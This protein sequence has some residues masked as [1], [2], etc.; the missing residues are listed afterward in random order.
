MSVARVYRAGSPFNGSELSEVD[1]EQSA[2]TMYLA[3]L[4]HV[5]TK[6]VRSAHTSWAFSDITFAPTISAPA[7]VA[8]T[9][10]YVNTDAPNTGAADN[11]KLARYVVTAIDDDT[12]QQSRVSSEVTATNTLELARNYNT[13]T[14]AA[15]TGAERYRVY[16]G[17]NAGGFGYIGTTTALTFKDD[18][19]GPDYSVGPPQSF[20][21]FPSAGNYPSTVSFFEQRLVWARTTNNPNA[22]YASRSGEYENMDITRPL[23]AS[24]SISFKLVAGRVNAVNQIV[25]MDSLIC[26]TSDGIFKITG[27]Q[28]GYVSPLTFNSKRQ[29]GRGGSR[30]GPLVIDAQAFY[31]T[32]VGNTVR[33]IG[34]EFQTDST[35]TNDVTIFSPHLFRGFNIVSWAYAQEP[36][37]LIWAARSDGKLL[38]FTWEREQQVWGWTICETD[39]LVETVAVISESGEDRLY[40]TVRRNGQLLIERMAAARWGTINDTCFLDSAVSYVFSTPQT[41][42][43]NLDHLNGKTVSALVDGNVVSGLVVAG[44]KVTLPDAA[45]NVTVGLPFTALIETLPLAQQGQNGLT[46]GK[47]QQAS[48]AVVRVIDTRGLK[49]GPSSDKLEVLRTRV[50]ELPGDPNALYTGLKETF[51]LPKFTGGASVVLQSDD[52]LPM[53]VTGVFIDPAISG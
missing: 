33:A 22:V 40:L 32:A 34:Y 31:Q 30:L 2:N 15:V 18:N 41:V 51:L 53:T 29:N 11:P 20:N 5:P 50:N 14:W 36:R 13:I 47:P 37:S 9:A 8:V 44:G 16:K 19:I 1:F 49:A 45:T 27:G 28:D 35:Q 24:D 43:N 52:P 4:N 38:C 12:G 17:T 26:V 46:I 48:K 3:H 10:T 21:P 42:C 23:V 39:G 25:S 7:S 6:L